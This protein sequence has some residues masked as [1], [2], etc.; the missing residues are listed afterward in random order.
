MK[1]IFVLF[2][3]IVGN[4]HA[5]TDIN[6]SPKVK[7]ILSSSGV[8][9]GFVVVI[10]CPSSNSGQAI[11][12]QLIRT[13]G[14]PYLVQFLDAEGD[15]IN[16]ARKAIQAE[17]LCGKVSAIA[18]DGGSL[19]YIDNL[20]NLVIVS[21]KSNVEH[22][23]VMR[24]LAPLGV[25]YINGKKTVK[26][27][28]AEI[29]EWTHYL[30]GPDNN[31]VAKDTV[32]APPK[33]MQWSNYPLWDRDHS[34]LNGFASMVS[35]KGRIFTIE[36]RA[37]ISIPSM[38]GKYTLVARDA[39]NGIELWK[40]P[41]PDWEN[42]T[43]HMKGAPPQLNRRMVAIGDKVYATPGITAPVVAF[44][45]PDGKIL[46]RYEGTK[47]TQEI[48]YY[49][50]VLYLVTGDSAKNLGYESEQQQ[51]PSQMRF[52]EKYYSPRSKFYTP[53]ELLEQ[54]RDHSIIAVDVLTG[55]RIWEISGERTK[56]YEGISLAVDGN[57][58][59]YQANK[60]LICVDRTTGK[61]L[62]KTPVQTSWLKRSNRAAGSNATIVMKDK[63][64]YRAESDG[65]KAYALEDGRLLWKSKGGVP[66][67]Y[68]SSP[69]LFIANGAV[70]VQNNHTGF[71]FLSGE[72]VQKRGDS[73]N[74]PMGHDR[75]HRN[76][77]TE[78]FIIES[79]SGGNDFSFLGSEDSLSHPWVRNTCSMGCMPCNGLL[80]ST[81]HA[82]G[83][84]NETV[85]NGVWALTGQRDLKLKT[86]SLQN[87]LV[88]G[89]AYKDITLSPQ[90]SNSW[91]TYRGNNSRSGFAQT[92]I[93]SELKP[94]WE[95]KLPSAPTQ[96]TIVDGR[97]YIASVDAHT[98]YSI[99][100]SNGKILW[101]YTAGGRID[102]PPTYHKGLL[103]FGS[104]DGWVYCLR[105]SDGELAWQF[106][107]APSR[108]H[109]ACAFNQIESLWPVN[110]SVLLLN[111]VAYFTAGRSTFLDGGIIMYGLDPVTG[112]KLHERVLSG[113]YEQGGEPIKFE[114]KHTAIYG[115]KNEIL[116]T[117]GKLIYLSHWAFTSDLTQ[118]EDVEKH[119]D[120]LM[121][122]SFMLDDA[123][124]HR[125]YWTMSRIVP[126]DRRVPQVAIPDGDLIV[127]DGR[128]VF[129]TRALQTGSNS[130]SLDPREKGFTL[131]S[132]T[133]FEK[134]MKT[135]TG[136][137]STKR[138]KNKS[139]I[140]RYAPVSKY[141]YR[142]NWMTGIH[143]N[144]EAMLM[145]DD[146]L[147]L[148]G[149]PNAFPEDDIFKGVEGRMGGLLI[150]VSKEDGAELAR[151]AL[152]DV[153]SW[154]GMSAED[155]KLFIS[156]KNGSVICFGSK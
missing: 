30:H 72:A 54:V 5:G 119:E 155:G 156:L 120:H 21:D 12:K 68:L 47:R 123:K 27:W 38:P 104:R 112:E 97:L 53:R 94:L 13:A 92:R 136:K 98:V 66:F 2:A 25:A 73:R 103:L 83:C 133:A 50:D 11:F 149:T 88:K 42:V 95:T 75:C 7:D 110:G 106:R 81:A 37:P 56:D 129:G 125:S 35:S 58:L 9:G 59:V 84:V 57:R 29:D 91:F 138:K 23:E 148:A 44:N 46:H 154:D 69:D 8:K 19:P 96:A 78:R 115:N 90:L 55:R 31:A 153:P 40:H 76:K 144:A 61:E 140:L 143:V 146:N 150:V 15:K 116:V 87:P 71:D 117:D 64:V 137:E 43:H 14:G 80:Y 151:Y 45:A 6:A 99:D 65:L 1:Y 20:V 39:F 100:G 109:L 152:K 67:G 62:W 22:D 131:F 101:S 79:K 85:L 121:T 122:G 128:R 126:S 111:D 77:A 18:F 70:W 142:E 102:T 82:C 60:Q 49:Q 93:P 34:T 51:Y 135:E 89:A 17:G 52:G 130:K 107:A 86:G 132:M 141:E 105:A 4:L 10:G 127:M 139:R 118:I 36:D 28:P 26:P 16:E 63:I 134:T 145:D 32:V 113:P 147:F 41:F 108:E 114:D 33:G 124:H 48:V 74:G 3:L 24:V